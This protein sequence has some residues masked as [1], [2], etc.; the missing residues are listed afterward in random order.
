MPD[1]RPTLDT[2]EP[3]TAL[4]ETL[5]AVDGD[6]PVS[7]LDPPRVY[8][9]AL[10]TLCRDGSVPARL[11]VIAQT[12]PLSWLR[13]HFPNATLLQGAVEADRLA[14]R[15]H[16]CD[17]ETPLA[18]GPAGAAPLLHVDDHAAS[19]PFHEG[20]FLDHL[21]DRCAALWDDAEVYGLRAPARETYRATAPDH[22]G[23]SFRD[24]F[25]EAVTVA[26]S[27][28][29]PTAFHPVRGAL[30][31]GAER[32]R[33]LYDLCRWGDAS[34][35]ASSASFSRHKSRLEADDVIETENVP[36]DVGRPRQRLFLADTYRTRL[37]E[38][39]RETLLRA[40]AV[41]E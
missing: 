13:D 22:L 30:V 41:I 28:D 12:G 26:A 25:D 27:L 38:G 10:A 37:A 39:D 7:L 35:V 4:R 11:R 6:G 20:E 16:D 15:R 32:E 23:E 2:T 33:L 3:A 19:V 24:A 18:V 5:A 40:A 36:V 29:D 31:V 1:E 21:R 9:D 34:G 14:I 17:R 8:L